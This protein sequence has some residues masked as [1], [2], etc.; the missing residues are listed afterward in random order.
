MAVVTFLQGH[1]GLVF[2]QSPRTKATVERLYKSN[3]L[4]GTNCIHLLKITGGTTEALAKDLY[5][6]D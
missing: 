4:T 6:A 3:C 2:T 5:V 1:M